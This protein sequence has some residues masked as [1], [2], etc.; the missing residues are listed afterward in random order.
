[1]ILRLDGSSL[2]LLKPKNPSTNNTAA[3][4]ELLGSKFGEMSTLMNHAFKSFN[5]WGH[6]RPRPFYALASA[7]TAEEYSHIETVGH[8]INLL[9]RHPP[10]RYRPRT[11]APSWRREQPQ[12]APLRR[13]R[14]SS[15]ARYSD[16]PPLVR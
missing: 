5:F 3:V 14:P 16:G 15:L 6:D 13:Q 2:E 10:A 8:P 4:Q 11:G 9:R 1:M 7:I 12:H